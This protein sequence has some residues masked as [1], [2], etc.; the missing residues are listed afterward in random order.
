MDKLHPEAEQPLLPSNILL[1]RLLGI[2]E[3]HP[4]VVQAVVDAWVPVLL[5]SAQPSPDA[6]PRWDVHARISRFVTDAASYNSAIGGEVYYRAKLSFGAQTMQDDDSGVITESITLEQQTAADK[7]VPFARAS[8]RGYQ[9][10]T[11]PEDR[12]VSTMWDQAVIDQHC[13]ATFIIPGDMVNPQRNGSMAE[14]TA[15][16]DALRRLS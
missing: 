13:P 9:R 3:I 11:T 6:R 1:D 2:E 5:S 4:S 8:G 7:W 15:F 14:L 16:T 10:P 12:N